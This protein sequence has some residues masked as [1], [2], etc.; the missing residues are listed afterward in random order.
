MMATSWPGTNETMCAGT[1]ASAISTESSPNVAT[2]F[3]VTIRTLAPET[4]T[5]VPA[6]TPRSR[7]VSAV[8]TTAPSVA[9]SGNGVAA[10]AGAAWT[11]ASEP[12]A[13]VRAAVAATFT[14]QG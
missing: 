8:T 14:D 4:A 2:C 5:M 6:P 11:N 10:L 1:T 12:S 3:A 13:R 7:S 9:R